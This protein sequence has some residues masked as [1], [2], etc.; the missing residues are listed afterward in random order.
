MKEL[1]EH[2]IQDGPLPDVPDILSIPT[3]ITGRENENCLAAFEKSLKPMTKI[4]VKQSSYQEKTRLF[5]YWVP[6][7][8]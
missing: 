1:E 6:Q 4:N 8:K 5:I 3:R 7:A 2:F